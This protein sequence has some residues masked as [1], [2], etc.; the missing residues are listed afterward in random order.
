MLCYAFL[1]YVIFIYL[2][3]ILCALF[4]SLAVMELHVDAFNDRQKRQELNGNLFNCILL[5][6]SALL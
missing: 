4:N 6:I 2:L 3:F 1:S 5:K